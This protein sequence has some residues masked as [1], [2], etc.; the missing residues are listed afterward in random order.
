[1]VTGESE[2]CKAKAKNFD[3]YFDVDSDLGRDRTCKCGRPLDPTGVNTRPHYDCA[4]ETTLDKA[5]FPQFPDLLETAHEWCNSDLVPEEIR[6]PP[7]LRG[8]YWM[9]GLHLDDVAFCLGLA[10]W[11]AETLTARIPVWSSFVVGRQAWEEVP[12]LT[13]ETSGRGKPWT[14]HGFGIGDNVLIYSITFTNDTLKQ[15][16]IV[17]NAPIFRTVGYHDLREIDQTADGKIV[18]KK[19]GDIF[20]RNTWIVGI[21]TSWYEAVRVMDDN[22]VIDEE[23]A[24]MMRAT[25]ANLNITYMRYAPTC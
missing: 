16:E 22:G 19:K 14:I 21:H 24:T 3:R 7:F 20:D 15:A 23:I 11:N 4:L 10:E 6:V 17:P 9:K 8:L 2:A 12:E 13:L 5:K 1:V 25:E 18:S